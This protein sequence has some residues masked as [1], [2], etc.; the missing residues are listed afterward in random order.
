MLTANCQLKFSVFSPAGRTVQQTNLG[1]SRFLLRPSSLV[2]A[3]VSVCVY[4]RA[5]AGEERG[6]GRQKWPHCHPISP[7]W[8]PA[9]RPA[10]DTDSGLCPTVQKRC[11]NVLHIHCGGGGGGGLWRGRGGR[12][13]CGGLAGGE[14]SCKAWNAIVCPSHWTNNMGHKTGPHGSPSISPSAVGAPAETGVIFVFVNLLLHTG[15]RPS[16]SQHRGGE[17]SPGKLASEHGLNQFH[18]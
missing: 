18:L 2:I 15:R 5:C 4:V 10:C 11:V 6:R 12:G 3:D 8:G 7:S 1:E 13:G 14:Y 9:H 16:A 17:V